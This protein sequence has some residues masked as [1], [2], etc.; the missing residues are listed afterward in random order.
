MPP[1][2]VPSSFVSTTPL[3]SAAS[4]N[5]R[6]WRRP[7]WPVVASIVSSVSCGAPSSWRAITRRTLLE[8][9]HQI[10]LGVQAPG[11]VDDHDVDVVRARL[12]DRLEGDRA[13][14]RAL[15]RR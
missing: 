4:A 3:T 8:L 2:A 6:A 13:R 10:V 5:M 11:G 9:A 15:A 12:G 14:V 1:R 7:F